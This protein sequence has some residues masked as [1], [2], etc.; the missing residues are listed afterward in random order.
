MNSAV[1]AV[2]VELGTQ[3]KHSD[4]PAEAVFG[5]RLDGAALWTRRS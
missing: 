5:N 3:R 1:Q 2:L 4:N